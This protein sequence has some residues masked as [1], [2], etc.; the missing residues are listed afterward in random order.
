MNFLFLPFT[1]PSREILL[2]KIGQYFRD[3]K[4]IKIYCFE[5]WASRKSRASLWVAFVNHFLLTEMLDIY[6]K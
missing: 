3:E 2:E 5:D 4:R 6:T 1:L